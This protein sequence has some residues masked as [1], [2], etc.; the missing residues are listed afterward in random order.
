[1][2]VWSIFL[3]MALLLSGCT[4]QP[5]QNSVS[6]QATDTSTTATKTSSEMFSDR[7]WDDSYDPNSPTITFDGDTITTTSDTVVVDGSTAT[8][9]QEGT[10]ILSG[11]LT[12]GTLLIDAPDTA[13]IQLV[14]D[15]VE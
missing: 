7:D 14:L 9:S 1:M 5:S 6:P 2:K 10:Y 11:T 4:A 13:K 15:G 3:C 8:I 12:D